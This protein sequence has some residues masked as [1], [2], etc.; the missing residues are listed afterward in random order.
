MKLNRLLSLM[1]IVLLCSTSVLVFAQDATPEATEEALAS[2]TALHPCTTIL[3]TDGGIAPQAAVYGD[4]GGVELT[5]D[6]YEPPPSDSPRAAVILIHGGAGSFGDRSVEADRAEG[7]ATNGY[8]AFNIDYRLL[9][10]GKNPWPAQIEDAQLAVRWIRA[11]A[12]KYNVD[13]ARICS[14]GHS[15]GGQLAALL[16]ERETP[17][18]DKVPLAEY[19]SKVACVVDIAGSL[20]SLRP[21]ND[22]TL[23]SVVTGLY[24]GTA[25][26]VRD[27][28]LSASALAQ[29]DANTA[30]FLI[31]HG[32][33]DENISVEESRQMV[34]ALHRAGVEVVYVEYPHATHFYWISFFKIKGSWDTVAPET[35]AFLGH[36]LK[37]VK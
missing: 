16:G 17:T 24:G 26:E 18:G 9:D 3:S 28:Y 34:D 7:L 20:D 11:N 33:D 21:I 15:F 13:P 27:N 32:A 5:L 10:E 14:L 25:Y 8:V 12:A 23:Q 19:S 36:H 29:V 30:P 22:V 1:I 37:A 6:V 2:C 31:F 35:L 4:V